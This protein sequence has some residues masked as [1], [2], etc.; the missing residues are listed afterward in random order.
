MHKFNN[1]DSHIL[2]KVLLIDN[3][4]SF[5]FN[6]SHYI[7]SDEQNKVDVIRNDEINISD[8]RKYDKIV[9]S[10]GP[11]LP[12]DAGRL[13]KVLDHIPLDMPVL[14]VCLGMQAYAEWTHLKIYNLSETKHG[15]TIQ[16]KVDQSNILF[17]G[18][19]ENIKVGLYHSWAVEE[20]TSDEWDF[21]AKSEEGVL[22]AMSHRK[23]PIHCVQFHPES[24]LTPR[25][26]EIIDNFISRT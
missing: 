3:Y 4:D 26:R 11:G 8:L 1:F 10:P 17:K 21:T 7:E 19:P 18:L 13:M 23:R 15:L 24:V 5:T 2:L 16:V 12:A 6:L 20:A 22:M 25:G 9:I 14:A